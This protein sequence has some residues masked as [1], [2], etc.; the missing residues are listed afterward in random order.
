MGKQDEW[1][2]QVNFVVDFVLLHYQ[3]RNDVDPKK[4]QFF[5]SSNKNYIFTLQLISIPYAAPSLILLRVCP[6]TF[7]IWLII[8]NGT[9]TRT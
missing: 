5:F 9:S 2:D 7:S 8:P 4:T 3:K 1:D 6:P